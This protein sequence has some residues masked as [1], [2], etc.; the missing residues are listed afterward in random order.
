MRQFKDKVEWWCCTKNGKNNKPKVC[1][2]IW[3]ETKKL[4]LKGI[5]HEGGFCKGWIR[6][7]HIACQAL[8]PPKINI[9]TATIFFCSL[10]HAISCPLSCP[11]CDATVLLPSTSLFSQYCVISY[12]FSPLTLSTGFVW[13]INNKL[14][15]LMV[16][17]N[18][19][20]NEY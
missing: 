1:S 3:L 16:L 20:A 9:Q 13:C 18:T 17:T 15:I 6:G 5:E 11:A 10:V 14:N 7:S 12:F 4:N 8:L 2:S 19:Q